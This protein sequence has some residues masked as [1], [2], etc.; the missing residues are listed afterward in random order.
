MIGNV[1][2]IGLVLILEVPKYCYFAYIFPL[3]RPPRN[4][5]LDH[6]EV[7]RVFSLSFHIERC[8]E[9]EPW[10][11]DSVRPKQNSFPLRLLIQSGHVSFPRLG[12]CSHLWGW[13]LC[14]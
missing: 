12:H 13:F 9:G 3:V 11:Y 14:Q 5:S 4:S 1:V 8:W 6:S 2:Y 10:P 7:L